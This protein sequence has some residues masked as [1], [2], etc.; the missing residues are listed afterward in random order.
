MLVFPPTPVSLG[1]LLGLFVGKQLGVF[2][3]SWL[4]VRFIGGSLPPGVTWPQVYGAG[5][6]A[7]V[8]F[9]MSLFISELAYVEPA[10][11]AHAKFGILLGSLIS[12]VVGYVILS[13]AMPKKTP[14]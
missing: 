12:G 6:L 13:R 2:L 1:I 10:M 9:T 7:G 8:G 14:E 3:F 4:A 11:L 5:C